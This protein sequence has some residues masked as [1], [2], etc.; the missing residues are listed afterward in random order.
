MRAFV[1]GLTMVV[2]ATAAWAGEK[3]IRVQTD[4][5]PVL[6]LKVSVDAKVVM[7]KEKTTIAP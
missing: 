4:G 3:R 7:T 1:I 2:L 5:V 6:T